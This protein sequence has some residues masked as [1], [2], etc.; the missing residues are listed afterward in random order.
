M[1]LLNL[2]GEYND[3]DSRLIILPTEGMDQEVLIGMETCHESDNVIQT[4][5]SRSPCMEERVHMNAIC[6]S[7][8]TSIDNTSV[9]RSIP[10]YGCGKGIKRIRLS[11][12]DAGDTPSTSRLRTSENNGKS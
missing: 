7:E 5:P 3:D 10:Q 9:V 2:T 11:E 6:A 4:T 1:C 12:Q 8:C